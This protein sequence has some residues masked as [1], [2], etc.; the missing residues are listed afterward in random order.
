M[1]GCTQLVEQ[2]IKRWAAVMRSRV[3][4]VGTAE[5][6]CVARSA[7]PDCLFFDAYRTE[8]VRFL[9]MGEEVVVAGPPGPH[10][11]AAGL[12]S[13]A[14][15]ADAARLAV[16]DPRHLAVVFPPGRPV[17]DGLAIAAVLRARFP[18]LVPQHPRTL[19]QAASARRSLVARLAAANDVVLVAGLL[20][21]QDEQSLAGTG[22]PVHTVGAVEEIR[23]EWLSGATAVGVLDGAGAPAGLTDRIVTALGGLGP[24]A[25]Y[26]HSVAIRARA[27]PGEAHLV[28]LSAVPPPG[29]RARV[30][31]ECCPC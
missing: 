4:T 27:E 1:N 28:A 29:V 3:V 31:E 20:D 7:K 9:G 2:E 15:P 26:E 19:C 6:C 12:R 25:V 17:E 30:P 21:Q 16:S 18:A 24:T 13:V 5:R 22:T 8:A 10:P 23:A 11:A 14:D